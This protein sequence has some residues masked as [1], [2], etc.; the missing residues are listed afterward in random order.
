MTVGLLTF[1]LHLPDARS[2]KNK[3][4]TVRR[5][6]DRLRS[7]YNVSVMELEEHQ[8]LWQRAGLAVVTIA[9]N[10]DVIENLFETIR[11]ETERLSPGPVI[12]TAR[13]YLE[14]GEGMAEG[15]DGEDWE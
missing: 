11:S 1:E 14:A 15:W 3:R 8:D 5:I 2:L 7:R 4:Q 13:D 12:E 6:K 9:S 10:R